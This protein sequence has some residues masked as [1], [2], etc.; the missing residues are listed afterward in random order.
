VD[1]FW[2][3]FRESVIVQAL[4]ALMTTM[5]IIYALLQG[6]TIPNDLWAIWG[7]IMGYYFG[8]K[9]QMAVNGTLQKVIDYQKKV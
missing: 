6:I 2:S 4:L 3:L 8:S 5:A 9:T 1:D 7:I